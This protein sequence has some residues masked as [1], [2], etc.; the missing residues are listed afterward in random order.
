MKRKNTNSA[1]SETSAGPESLEQPSPSQPAA[2]T[3][4]FDEAMNSGRYRLYLEAPRPYWTARQRYDAT[5]RLFL[6]EDV[7]KL[8]PIDVRWFV[9]A[10]ETVEEFEW[11]V[12][13]A[14]HAWR[15]DAETVYRNHVI[16]VPRFEIDFPSMIVDD[17]A[18]LGF[19]RPANPDTLWLRAEA[20]AW[21]DGTT[22]ITD[23]ITHECR[24]LWQYYNFDDATI[25]D[26]TASEYDAY[27]YHAYCAFITETLRGKEG[28]TRGSLRK[29]A[30]VM[31]DERL[32]PDAN[33]K[34]RLT[35][36]GTIWHLL[37]PDIEAARAE[38][39]VAS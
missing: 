10:G 2:Q 14:A 36:V 34:C 37:Y 7:L 13:D 21:G 17:G 30:K 20:W 5:R 39:E 11:A 6:M 26:E 8:P 1:T 19:T 12:K 22:I 3:I 15:C 28:N 18:A 4:T 25:A 32:A 31:R 33:G 35:T 16:V 24:H 23:T 38:S 27:H 29:T 9:D